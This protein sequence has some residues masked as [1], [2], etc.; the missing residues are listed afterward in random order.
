MF[1]KEGNNGLGQ[2]V[3]RHWAPSSSAGGDG[4]CVPSNT[5]VMASEKRVQEVQEGPFSP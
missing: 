5:E 1:Q 4:V 2:N 3:K